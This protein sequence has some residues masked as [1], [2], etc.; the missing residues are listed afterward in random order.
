MPKNKKRSRRSIEAQSSRSTDYLNDNFDRFSSTEQFFDDGE[1]ANR[2]I[3]NSK[4]R[5]SNKR[6][7]CIL[8]SPTSAVH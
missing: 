1:T 2:K 6:V 3:E 4:A 7:I 8:K 5:D